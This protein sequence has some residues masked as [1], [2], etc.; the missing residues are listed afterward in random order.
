[1]VI[2]WTIYNNTRDNIYLS[3]LTICF[4]VGYHSEAKYQQSLHSNLQHVLTILGVD[5]RNMLWLR[6]SNLDAKQSNK[7][8][9]IVEITTYVQR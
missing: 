2:F 9:G 7:L 4:I 6:K 5:H 3:V 1:M 8:A